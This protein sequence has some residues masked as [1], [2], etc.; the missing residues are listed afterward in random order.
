MKPQLID[1]RL[2][3]DES[4]G[5]VGAKYIVELAWIEIGQAT[6]AAWYGTVQPR[7]GGPTCVVAVIMRGSRRD[8]MV[9]GRS[10]AARGAKLT[11]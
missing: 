4:S 9:C 10:S 7:L 6:D 2:R 5:D 8:G 3:S 11:V 1:G